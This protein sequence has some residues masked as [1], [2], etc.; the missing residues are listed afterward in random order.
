VIAKYLQTNLC[1]L[2]LTQ[3]LFLP[4]REATADN[5]YLILWRNNYA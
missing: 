1:V 2:L 5:K 3:A 4:V